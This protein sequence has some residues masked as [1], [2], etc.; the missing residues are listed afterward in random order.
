METEEREEK[1]EKKKNIFTIFN[2]LL[3][4]LLFFYFYYFSLFSLRFFRLY[5]L[6]AFSSPI[7]RFIHL[8]SPAQPASSQSRATRAHEKRKNFL[9]SLH[10]SFSFPMMISALLSPH[11]V[12]FGVVC[13]GRSSA[14]KRRA[15]SCC[16][17]F[18]VK[19]S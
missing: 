9:R 8:N 12:P 15:Q 11:S 3:L 4:A 6:L 2:L 13:L 5:M 7:P 18:S 17:H 16:H 19:C 1:N 10:A 14:S